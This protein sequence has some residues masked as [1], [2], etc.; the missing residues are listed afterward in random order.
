MGTDAISRDAGDF[1][2]TA[3]RRATLATRLLQLRTAAGL[4]PE[5][6]AVAARLDL[7]Y[8][9][10]ME[11]GRADLDLLTYLDVLDLA[12]ALA[13]RPAQLFLDDPSGQE[14][15]SRP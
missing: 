9:R 12:E 5:Q 8:Y 10:D 7:G 6:V 3:E 11:G 15:A 14:P 13:V 4:S 2:R 1:R